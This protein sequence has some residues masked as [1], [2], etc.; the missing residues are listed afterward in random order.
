MSTGRRVIAE[1]D[2]EGGDDAQLTFKEGDVIVVLEEHDS[3]WWTGRL[4]KNGKEGYFPDT[5]VK[6][7]KQGGPPPPPGGAP[8]G[9]GKIES[10]QMEQTEKGITFADS[11]QVNP[12]EEMY[13]SAEVLNLKYNPNARTRYG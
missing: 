12:L 9:A 11:E 10:K 1:Y 6:Q 3:G 7:V 4:E 5:Y 13:Y 8:D 2:Y